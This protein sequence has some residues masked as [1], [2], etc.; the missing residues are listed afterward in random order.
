MVKLK[1][2]RKTGRRTKGEGAEARPKGKERRE[3]EGKW[4]TY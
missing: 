3:T 2:R 4:S 1:G